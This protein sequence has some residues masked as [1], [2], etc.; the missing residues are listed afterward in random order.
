MTYHAVFH[1]LPKNPENVR[2]VLTHRGRIDNIVPSEENMWVVLENI[3]TAKNSEK[4]KNNHKHRHR[5]HS[6]NGLINNQIIDRKDSHSKNG[7]HIDNVIP[8]S[9]PVHTVLHNGD[10]LSI[11]N[12]MKSKAFSLLESVLRPD[13]STKE[14]QQGKQFDPIFVVLHFVSLISL[15]LFLSLSL[16]LSLTRIHTY[17]HALTFTL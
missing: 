13:S 17:S 12:I 4:I 16:Y 11:E 6:K 3:V 9:Y 7:S 8:T 5:D 10:F 2:I 1:T 14:W 15:S